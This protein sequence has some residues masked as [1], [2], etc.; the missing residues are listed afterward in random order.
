[1]Q[2]LD[3]GIDLPNIY[4]MAV[5]ADNLTEFKTAVK[6]IIGRGVRLGKEKREFD[7]TTDELLAQAEKLHVVCDQGAAFEEVILSIQKEFG[8]TDKYL[9][10]EGERKKTINRAKSDRLEG[11]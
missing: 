9:S 6:Q 8:L 7:N 1:M 3:E 5:V 11:L 10:I 4:S 2:R